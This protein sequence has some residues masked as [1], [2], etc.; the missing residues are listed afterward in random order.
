MKYA[1]YFKDN[2][3]LVCCRLNKSATLQYIVN[4]EILNNNLM[5]QIGSH[6]YDA[7]KIRITIKHVPCIKPIEQRINTRKSGFDSYSFLSKFL[8]L[9]RLARKKMLDKPRCYML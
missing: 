4:N 9:N 1:I 8:K 3:K 6:F 7:K 2:E 5:V